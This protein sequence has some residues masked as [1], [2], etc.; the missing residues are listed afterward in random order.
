[1]N[2][3]E[4][5][6]RHLVWFIV[7]AAAGG[8]FLPQF[9]ALSNYVSW[10][11]FVMIL[12]LGLTLE[13]SEFVSVA[14]APWKVLAAVLIKYTAI[15]LL[16]YALSLLIVD[17]DLAI[18][19]LVI[20][21]AP[22]EITSALMVGLADGNVVLGATIM[23]FSILISPFAM[24]WILSITSG[25]ST[26]LDT[27]DLFLQL[28]LIV[29]VP[30]MIG[31]SIRTKFKCLKRYKEEFTSLSSLMVILLIFAVASNS[32]E[33]ILDTSLIGLALILLTLNL[34]GYGAGYLAARILRIKEVKSYIFTIGMKEFGIATA[35]AVQFFDSDAAV[36]AA[37][38]GVIMLVT[39]PI[40][41]RIL[42]N[43]SWQDRA[44]S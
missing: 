2:I 19:T 22:S 36:P 3:S 4:V 37:I 12:G 21:A 1:M 38:Y 24:P 27:F 25:S 5:I 42:R 8:F 44:I 33:Q 17:E 7:L 30:V 41:T 11:L 23:I 6:N 14:K 32:A 43:R 35:V 40:M 28:L 31:L 18:G 29:V 15:P 13:L 10:I 20:G 26:S 34:S 39:A 9:A 16:A